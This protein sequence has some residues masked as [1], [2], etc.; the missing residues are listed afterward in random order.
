MKKMMTLFATLLLATSVY[1]DR[2]MEIVLVEHLPGEARG[3]CIHADGHQR[4]AIMEGG[5]QGHTCYS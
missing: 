4:K 5:V 3:W 2:S 1:S